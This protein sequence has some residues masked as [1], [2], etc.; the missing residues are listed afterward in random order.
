ME[1]VQVRKLGPEVTIE[2]L[3]ET[4][5]TTSLAPVIIYL[6]II[7]DD[8]SDDMGISSVPIIHEA[9]TKIQ[10]AQPPKETQPMEVETIP[11]MI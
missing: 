10:Y 8:D 7:Y 1:Q 6:I 3:I 2:T 4:L 11:R 5:S 9:N